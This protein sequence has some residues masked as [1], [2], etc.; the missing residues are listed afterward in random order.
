[1]NDAVDVSVLI[2]NWNAREFL[3]PCLASLQMQSALHNVILVDNASTDGSVESVRANFPNVHLI[4]SEKNLGFAAG[5]NR[6]AQHSRGRYLLLLNPDTT[7]PPGALAK[8]VAY[9]D[10]HPEIGALGPQLQNP[11]GTPQRS[12][13][14]GF[15]GLSMA[16]TDALYLWKLPWLP[17]AQRSEYRAEEL[18]APRR[19]DHLL[20]ACMLI[21]RAAWE[22]VGALD[23][24]YFLFLEETDW[25]LRAQRAGWQ[26]VY[27]PDTHIVHFG[28]QS[29][30]QAPSKNI[31]Q[32]YASYLRFYRAQHGAKTLRAFLLKGIIAVACL[33]RI[34]MW[35]ERARRARDAAAREVAR[36]MTVGYRQTLS[37]LGTL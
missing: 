26:I 24:N 5:N 8:L 30:R 13:W 20:G 14:R 3:R 17:F 34:G 7:V 9:A 28:Q 25:C 2:V 21:R 15:P 10:A 4:A 18:Q 36:A 35:R 33:I 6:A 16:L 29:M 12:C 19:V 23:E 31:P 22:Q 37:Q 32:F 1:M 11:D 27:F